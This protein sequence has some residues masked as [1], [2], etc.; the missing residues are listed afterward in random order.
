MIQ[1]YMKF[2][3]EEGGLYLSLILISLLL[4]NF[5]A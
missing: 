1:V 4:M 2:V 5:N 3:K